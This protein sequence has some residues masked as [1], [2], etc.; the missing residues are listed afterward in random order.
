[1][2]KKTIKKRLTIGF[3]EYEMRCLNYYCE[4]KGRGYSDVIRDSIRKFVI[5]EVEELIRTKESI[6]K[7]IN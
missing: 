4:K 2:P 7:L 1:M 6:N 5:A 3:S